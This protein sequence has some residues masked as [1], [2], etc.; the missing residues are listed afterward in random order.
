MHFA[1]FA[2]L[3]HNTDLGSLGCSDKVMMNR[4]ACEQAA[5]CNAVMTDIAIRQHNHRVPFID[6]LFGF[7]AYA[8]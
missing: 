1:G 7:I 2:R 6:R 8:I 4:T 3:Q 5:G